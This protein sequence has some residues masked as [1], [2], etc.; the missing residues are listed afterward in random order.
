M[1]IWMT[2]QVN[3]CIQK[4]EDGMF[5]VERNR[6]PVKKQTL[7]SPGHPGAQL[8]KCLTSARILILASWD[9]GPCPAP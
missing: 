9:R 5:H 7:G 6:D 2:E 8:V 4:H 1:A 3:E